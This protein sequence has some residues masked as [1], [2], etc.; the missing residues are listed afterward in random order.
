MNHENALTL[1]LDACLQV[2]KGEG[3]D[4]GE[5][6]PL[7]PHFYPL[8]RRGEEVLLG[9]GYF[10]SNQRFR[11]YY[12]IRHFFSLTKPRFVVT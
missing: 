5:P 10:L 6:K 8:P 9:S 2:G 7:P 11:E 4:E 12:K 1:S 3:G